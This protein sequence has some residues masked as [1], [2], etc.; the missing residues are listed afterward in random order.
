MIF[1][2]DLVVWPDGDWCWGGDIYEMNHKID[3]YIVYSYGTPEWI[4]FRDSIGF[5]E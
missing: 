1:T 5:V 4:D 2:D 3:D